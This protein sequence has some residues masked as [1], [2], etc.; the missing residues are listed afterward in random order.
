MCQLLNLKGDIRLT[1]GFENTDGE[2]VNFRTSL[3]P[4]IPIEEIAPWYMPV[5]YTQVFEDKFP[6]IPGLSIL[7]L[8]FCVGPGALG[9]LGQEIPC[10]T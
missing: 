6:F 10:K 7:D 3:S 4:K 8:L 5:E 2:F 9:Y 1:K